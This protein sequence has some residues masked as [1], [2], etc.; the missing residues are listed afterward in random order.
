MT[1]QISFYEFLLGTD[2]EWFGKGPRIP[3]SRLLSVY[4][5]LVLC[6]IATLFV[7]YELIINKPTFRVQDIPGILL[8]ILAIWVVS[9]LHIGYEYTRFMLCKSKY[10]GLSNFLGKIIS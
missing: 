7:L 1:K 6:M 2:I 4:T 8:I 9:L 5:T 10:T 3:T